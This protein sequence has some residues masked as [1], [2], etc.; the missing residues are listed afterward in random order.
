MN[1]I[2]YTRN[3]IIVAYLFKLWIKYII[4]IHFSSS[5]SIGSSLENCLTTFNI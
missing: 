2:Y 3:N 1:A 5:S 4:I